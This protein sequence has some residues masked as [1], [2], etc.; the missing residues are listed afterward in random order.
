MIKFLKL[1]AFLAS[2]SFIISCTT[3]SAISS[4]TKELL[5]THN[6]STSQ[7]ALFERNNWL[8][9]FNNKKLNE[10]ASIAVK[11]NHSLKVKKAN[12]L[13]AAEQLTISDSSLLPQL[14]LDINNSRRKLVS[15]DNTSFQNSADI[16]AKLSY[17]VDFWG[18]LS[19]QQK[20]SSLL[21][22]AQER[23]YYDAEQAL[24]ISVARAWYDLISAKQLGQ[25]Y[26][27]RV[28][29]LS[30]NLTTIQS[31][32]RL[33][34]RD[35]LD[36]YLTQNNVSSEQAR[37]IQQQQ[38]IKTK[39][40]QLEL[41][42]G[43]DPR[44]IITADNHLPQLAD[45]PID[46]NIPLQALTKRP[47]ILASWYNMLALDAGLAVAHKAR[48]PRFTVNAS[49]GDSNDEL[50]SLLSGNAL[51][52]SLLG[53]ITTPLFNA[54]RLSSL[55]QQ[56]R[57]K[58]SQQEQSYLSLLF[59]A[60]AQTKNAI[61]NVDALK[62]RYLLVEQAKNNALIAETLSFKQYLKGLVSYATVLESQRRSFDAQTNL[63][64]INNQLIQNRIDLYAALGGS[65]L[66]ES[67][68]VSNN[69][70]KQ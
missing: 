40:R 47:D 34:L 42:L 61:D 56:A 11:N 57:L 32:Y 28:A 24:V 17:E 10:L 62:S 2:C 8:Q 66:V 23:A 19:D 43:Q 18:K 65:A 58:V 64:Q 68:A 14:T 36:V 30:S 41:L 39:Q 13:I 67:K 26:Q 46:I 53:N 45:D 60:L 69:P 35:A 29:N 3:P 7:L 52:W 49:I 6:Q 15:S 63:I 20:Q 12:L 4:K 21:Y 51:G 9:R 38:V 31:S 70:L 5:S 50:T 25:L 33:G 54:G 16:T 55:E 37:V 59:D 27:Q 48:F 22:K 1:G 44:G